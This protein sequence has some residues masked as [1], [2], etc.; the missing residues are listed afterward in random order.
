ML[1]TRIL[2]LPMHPYLTGDEVSRVVAALRA[3]V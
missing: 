1:C 2:S 3:A